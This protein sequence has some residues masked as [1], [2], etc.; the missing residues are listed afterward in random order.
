MLLRVSLIIEAAVRRVV[1]LR[2]ALQ[3][4]L[5]VGNG[6]SAINA[7][8]VTRLSPRR[9]RHIYIVRLHRRRSN[10]GA[11]KSRVYA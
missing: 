7:L 4:T 3:R 2:V 9:A 1:I 10:E 6:A 5:V 8:E 11:V